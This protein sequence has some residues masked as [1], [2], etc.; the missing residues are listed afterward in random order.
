MSWYEVVGCSSAN[1]YFC[2][3]SATT[4]FKVAH[5]N[6]NVANRGHADWSVFMRVSRLA[7]LA[8]LASPALLVAVPAFAVTP[9]A[10]HRAVYDLVLD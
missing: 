6:V 9:L 3:A 8:L 2:L 5:F 1:C 4:F 10:P 7:L